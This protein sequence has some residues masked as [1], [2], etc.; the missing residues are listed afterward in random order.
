MPGSQATI[1]QLDREPEPVASIQGRSDLAGARDPILA[2]NRRDLNRATAR[3]ITENET[4]ELLPRM[5]A[6]IEAAKE[7]K[8]LVA[9]GEWAGI[10]RPDN[11]L[12]R[13]LSDL[14]EALTGRP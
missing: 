2:R 1:K 4:A 5:E 8:Q 3:R 12:R 13:A 10:P 7:A 6:A 11:S 9:L 14:A